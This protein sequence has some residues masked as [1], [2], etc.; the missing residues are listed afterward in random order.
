MN[1]V[2]AMVPAFFFLFGL[3]GLLALLVLLVLGIIGIVIIMKTVFFVLP[4][5]VVAFAVWLITRNEVYAGIAFVAVAL[6]SILKR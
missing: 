4:A 5:A 3:L 1:I 6:L 2:K